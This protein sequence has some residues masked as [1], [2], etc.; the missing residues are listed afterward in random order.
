MEWKKYGMGWDGKYMMG[1]GIRC[2]D[3]FVI[4]FF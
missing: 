1:M 2:F 4:E 3:W